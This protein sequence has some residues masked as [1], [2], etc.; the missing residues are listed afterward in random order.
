MNINYLVINDV[1]E[2]EHVV[3]LEIQ[4]WDLDPRDAVPYHLL[5]A[6][7]VNGGVLIG[8]YDEAEIVGVAFGFPAPRPEGWILWS[9]MTAVHPAYQGKGIGSELKRFQRRWAREHGYREIRWTFDPLQRGNAH[10]NLH[11]LG[12]RAAQYHV[13]FYGR[14]T[15]GIN[16]GM[17]SDRLEA[18]WDIHDLPRLARERDPLSIL[19]IEN[20][21][22]RVALPT[23]S[24]RPLLIHIPGVLK[25][26]SYEARLEWRLA[27]RAAFGWAFDRG[28][29]AVDFQDE[30]AG[31]VYVLAKTR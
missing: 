18:V 27:L 19:K 4:V 16:R 1:G 21:H 3:D 24:N 15:D 31:G 7:T 14:M 13:D 8:A 9:H 6:V 26:L 11:L 23:D 25:D 29:H 12:A 22:P 17:P 20:G 5:R 28:Y 30:S 10:L 2:L